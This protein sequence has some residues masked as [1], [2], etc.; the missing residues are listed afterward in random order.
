MKIVA[1]RG[2]TQEYNENTLDAIQAASNIGC[3]NIEIDVILSSDNTIFLSHDLY[4]HRGNDFEKLSDEVLIERH[5]LSKLSDILHKFEH[6]TFQIDIKSRKFNIIDC[7]FKLIYVENNYNNCI[8]TSFN[9]KHLDNILNHENKYNIQIKKG[10]ITCN[11]HSD[12]FH[13][14][15]NKYKLDLIVIWY[16]HIDEE[17]IDEIK[18]MNV[19]ISVYTVNERHI[20]KLCKK[21]GINYIVTDYPKS[22][23]PKF[24]FKKLNFKK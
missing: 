22:F 1:H 18:K 20:Y 6:I 16:S 10:Y 13:T 11:R 2:L 4:S 24:S 12:N 23:L 9:E 5:N 19:K 8:L 7:L 3:E 17:L 14:L 21:L 15:I